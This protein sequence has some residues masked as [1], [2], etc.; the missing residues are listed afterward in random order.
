MA[1]YRQKYLELQS[2]L[3]GKRVSVIGLGRSNIPLLQFLVDIGCEVIARDRKDPAAMQTVVDAHSDDKIQFRLGTEYLADLQEE[4][5]FLT[6][7]MPKDLP[8]IRQ[9]VALG[10]KID[11]EMGLFLHLCQA[12]TIGIT[13]SV[14]KTTTTSIAGAIFKESGRPTYVGGNI[15]TPLLSQAAEIEE[16][17][18]V[19]L[20]LSSFQLEMLSES[21]RIAAVLNLFPN[22]LD[23]HRSMEEYTEAK[24]NIFRFQSSEDTLILNADNALTYGMRNEAKGKVFLFSVQREIRDGDSI[25]LSGDRIM[26]HMNGM[27]DEICRLEDIVLPGKHNLGNFMVAAAIARLSDVD[28]D[29]IL[30]VARSF[31]GIEHRI[32]FVR[33]LR[34]VRYYNDSKATTPESTIS[35]VAAFDEPITLIAGGYDKHVSFQQLAQEIVRNVKTLIL[36]GVTAE[37]IER[38]VRDAMGKDG[39]QLNIIRCASFEEAVQI[40]AETEAGG[41][42]LLSPACASYDM[43]NNYEERG[44]VFTRLVQNLA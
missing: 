3:A 31:S 19:I 1:G 16:N 32:S 24:K 8:E 40:S 9:A 21:T 2:R 7:G 35:A 41:V 28:K 10:A 27:E 22:H 42:V 34:G 14:G 15:G 30:K 43:F 38:E 25:F 36:I 37:Q 18:S 11:S 29:S 6:P 23:Q 17:A 5:L 4:I 39:D 13:G 33:E 26:M 12:R 20:E 44:H